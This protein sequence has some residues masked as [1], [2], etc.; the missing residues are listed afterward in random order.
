MPGYRKY[1]ARRA[2]FARKDVPRVIQEHPVRV[3]ILVSVIGVILGTPI[4][5]EMGG[6][7]GGIVG[8]IIGAVGGP[9]AAYL[10]LFTIKFLSS[11]YA[12]HEL[13]EADLAQARQRLES[14]A[15]QPRPEGP[16]RF[17]V[18]IDTKREETFASLVPCYEEEEGAET[19]APARRFACLSL[20]LAVRFENHDVADT[21]VIG[22]R[23]EF[24]LSATEE[25]QEIEVMEWEFVDALRALTIRNPMAF[26]VPLPAR[27]P[28]ILF[29]HLTS[30]KK[31]SGEALDRA[32]EQSFVRAVVLSL[33]NPDWHLDM[34]LQELR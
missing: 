27:R 12:I 2:D 15:E 6:V 34:P 10:I 24:W 29:S 16:V 32:S 31:Y 22:F 25:A 9:I 8:G 4:G 3:G 19:G 30:T 20:R 5:V 17:E 26:A 7:T 21:T 13:Q 1:L 14:L 28:Q 33:G 23:T 18:L 11:S